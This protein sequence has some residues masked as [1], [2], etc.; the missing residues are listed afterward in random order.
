V[1]A[2]AGR[3]PLN[4]AAA[5]WRESRKHISTAAPDDYTTSNTREADKTE[6]KGHQAARANLGA[7]RGEATRLVRTGM[8]RS[9]DPKG[10][11]E[12]PS[13]LR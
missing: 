4:I 6:G 1:V 13:G 10:W 11:E 3:Q 7:L 9:S 12:T 2:A 8:D 5:L